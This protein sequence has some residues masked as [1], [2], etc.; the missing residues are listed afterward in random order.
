MSYRFDIYNTSSMK[1]YSKAKN[2]SNRRNDNIILK[3][4]VT[5]FA[6]LDFY[7]TIHDEGLSLRARNSAKWERW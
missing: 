5:S 4:I 7:D 2:K 6:Y 3:R 1:P